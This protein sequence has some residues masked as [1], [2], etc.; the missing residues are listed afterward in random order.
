[1]TRDEYVNQ[2][3]K[4][5]A[6]AV[7]PHKEGGFTIKKL[8]PLVTDNPQGN[9]QWLHN[10]T[11]IKDKEVYLRYFEGE[12]DLS[13]VEYCKKECMEKCNSDIDAS[14]EEFAEH[15]DCGCPISLI[16]HMAVGHA[17]LRERLKYFEANDSEV[18]EGNQNG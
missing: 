1:M 4:F 16:Y 15:M 2:P 6:F 14:V 11:V 13:L 7:L 3:Y 18:V 17:E 9:Y 8:R 10:M 12:G 5:L